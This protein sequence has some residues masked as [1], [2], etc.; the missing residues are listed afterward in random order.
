[1]DSD[2]MEGGRGVQI[3]SMSFSLGSC[4]QRSSNTSYHPCTGASVEASYLE[5]TAPGATSTLGPSLVRYEQ[6]SVWILTRRKKR[7]SLLDCCKDV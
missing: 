3:P 4:R 6:W 7:Q 2:R 1:M 5:G